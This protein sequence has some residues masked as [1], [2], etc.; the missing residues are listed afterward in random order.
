MTSP[1]LVESIVASVREFTK[2]APQSDDITVMVIRYLG[3]GVVTC[4]ALAAVLWL[5]LGV[6]VWNGFFD[7]YVSRGARE[8]GQLRVGARA[9]TRARTG[10]EAR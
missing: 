7:L 3:A 9:R 4:R 8:Y 2:G 10:H 6:A 5:V 1:A